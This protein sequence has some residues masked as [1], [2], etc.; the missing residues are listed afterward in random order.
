MVE[1]NVGALGAGKH[2]AFKSLWEPARG[3]AKSGFSEPGNEAQH[4]PG[5]CAERVSKGT[6][7]KQRWH[8]GDGLDPGE[9]AGFKCSARGG[10]HHPC[11]R[12]SL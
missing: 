6:K 5:Q 4:V 3:R 7:E 9:T 11:R 2:S 10:Q 1:E 8:D 12:E